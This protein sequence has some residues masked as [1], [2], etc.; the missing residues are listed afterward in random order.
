MAEIEALTKYFWDP[1]T[2]S[3][4]LGHTNGLWVEIEFLETQDS[5]KHNVRENIFPIHLSWLLASLL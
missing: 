5:T 4:F 3:S 1:P 2:D